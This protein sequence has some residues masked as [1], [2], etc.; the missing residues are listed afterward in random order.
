MQFATTTDTLHPWRRDA[1]ERFLRLMTD[2]GLA[3]QARA[4]LAAHATM[5]PAPA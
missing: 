5:S 2:Q 3:P 4:I 1:Q